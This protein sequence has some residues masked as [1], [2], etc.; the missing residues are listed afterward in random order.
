MEKE[1]CFSRH[2]TMNI[3]FVFIFLLGFWIQAPV[4][5]TGRTC[6]KE[7]QNSRPPL[8]QNKAI[9]RISRTSFVH[10]SIK[11][12]YGAA[13]SVSTGKDTSSFKERNVPAWVRRMERYYKANQSVLPFEMLESVLYDVESRAGVF[14]EDNPVLIF[15]QNGSWLEGLSIKSKRERIRTLKQIVRLY[16][17]GNLSELSNR[18]EWRSNDFVAFFKMVLFSFLMKF[19]A[20]QL[21]DLILN[22]L[23]Q[24]KKNNNVGL[25]VRRSLGFSMQRQTEGREDVFFEELGLFLYNL[26]KAT[27]PAL[28]K[29]IILQD[30][31]IQLRLY[32]DDPVLLIDSEDSP[33]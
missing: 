2:K 32:M 14:K 12:I 23:D 17:E 29:N 11:S 10:S 16:N 21:K 25:Y 22:Q 19:P 8:K 13:L 7:F 18:A 30:V 24:K 1:V 6:Q 9:V 20:K 33:A 31:F 3:Y 5:A 27:S 28:L 26:V 4:Y 15:T